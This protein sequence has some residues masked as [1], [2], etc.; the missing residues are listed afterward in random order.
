MLNP[1]QLR[2]DHAFQDRGDGPHDEKGAPKGSLTPG[3]QASGR[4]L[5]TCYGHA[6]TRTWPHYATF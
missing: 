4:N 3:L 2:N 5:W 6:K 1:L